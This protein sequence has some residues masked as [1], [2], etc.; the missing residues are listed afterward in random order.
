LCSKFVAQ[1]GDG[2][3]LYSFFVA[4]AK[5]W[6]G[7]LQGI[8]GWKLRRLTG[9]ILGLLRLILS[10]A[11][12]LAHVSGSRYAMTGGATSVQSF[13][14]ISGFFI[15]MILDVKYTRSDQR[16]L[17]YSNR[18]LRIYSIYL[19][20][21]GLTVLFHLGAQIA[22]HHS[23]FEIWRQNIARM[24]SVGAGFLALANLLIVGQDWTLFLLLGE[25]GLHWT[26]HFETGH[27]FLPAFMLIP[28]AWSLSVELYFY[29][30]APFI[31]RWR[32]S[33]LVALLAL[34]FC[35]R[36]VLWHYD[37]RL[38]PWSYRFFPIELGTF[39]VGAL[40]YRLIYL[41]IRDRALALGWK[42]L[43]CLIFP[44]VIL[45]PLYDRSGGLFFTPTQIVFYGLIAIAVPILFKMT[46][47]IH[48]DRMLGELSYPLYLCHFLVLSVID[49]FEAHVGGL[50]VRSALGV[51]LSCALAY[52]SV[53]ALDAPIDR[54]RQRRV[55]RSRKDHG[56]APIP[57]DAKI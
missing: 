34:T 44:A 47:K 39:L 5:S 36:G 2:P 57:A 8:V 25:H 19:V 26:T 40:S 20:F 16:G 13:Y 52:V 18:L 6:S 46:G 11:V 29:L 56:Q 15:A 53:I 22:T 37:L 28:Q 43:A 12:V 3:G 10:I 33:F 27:P 14:I 35:L 45:Y 50:V 30:L 24:G 31:L 23:V 4:S 7:S 32:T 54:F 1:E 49:H 9:G 38:D 51:A 42:L 48:S 21:L 41:K 17:F 55:E